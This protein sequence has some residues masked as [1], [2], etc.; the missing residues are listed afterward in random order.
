MSPPGPKRQLAAVQRYGPCQWNTGR[1]V[2]V[3]DTTALDPKLSSANVMKPDKFMLVPDDI[4]GPGGAPAQ[5]G[6][7]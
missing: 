7:R 2:D 5:C 3:P 6:S 4:G 1:S